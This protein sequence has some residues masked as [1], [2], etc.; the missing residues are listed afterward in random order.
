M[1]DTGETR[2]NDVIRGDISFRN[3]L[4]DDYIL[5]KSDGFPTYHLANIVDDHLMQTTHVIRGEEWLSSTPKH[6]LLYRAFAW[7]EPQFIHLPLLLNTDR[8]KLSKRQGDVTVEEYL[9]L[10]Y[11]PEA[12]INF[13][14]LLGWN[15]GTEQEIFSLE[16]LVKEFSFERI[17][18]SGAVFDIAKLNW[19]NK[20]YINNSDKR[21]STVKDP[22]V[23]KIKKTLELRNIVVKDIDLT[24][25][26]IEQRL[27][28]PNELIKIL[29]TEFIFLPQK[30]SDGSVKKLNYPKELLIWKKMSD[31]EELKISLD[32]IFKILSDIPEG[33][34]ASQVEQILLT[35][36]ANKGDRGMLLWPL[37]VALSGQK[38]SPGPADIAKILGKEETLERVKD[39]IDK[40]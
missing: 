5:L 18:K 21:W 6:V 10:G 20:Y 2:F 11:F 12:I 25:S 13:V 7:Q 23:E 17:N 30:N 27:T 38:V 40:I 16:D 3:D 9:R 19:L 28:G 34:W 29:D 33:V 14:A 24:V 32:E 37:R 31:E 4:M 36:A 1:P 35:E 8:S 26:A 22:L 15:P 39:A